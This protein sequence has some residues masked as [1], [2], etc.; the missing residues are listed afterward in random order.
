MRVSAY[1]D[2]LGYLTIGIGHLQE[3]QLSEITIT[4]EHCDSLFEADL[5]I[6]KSRL[7]QIYPNW[8]KLD[9]NMGAT[10]W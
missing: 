9:D 10:G 4:E 8:K 2:S 5:A 3:N 6:A 1:R 7:D